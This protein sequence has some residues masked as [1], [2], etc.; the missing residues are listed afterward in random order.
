MYKHE[1]TKVASLVNRLNSFTATGDNNRLLQTAKIQMR[2]LIEPSHLDLRCLTFS[3][4]TLHINVFPNDSL[5]KKKKKK[6]KKADDKCR[7]KFGTER[8]KGIHGIDKGILSFY[9]RSLFRR[10]LVCRKANRKQQ[11]FSPLYKNKSYLP[12]NDHHILNFI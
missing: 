11:K 10:G 5:K 9:S 12:G 7:L 6:K 2:R 4:S 3:L 1:V 8:V